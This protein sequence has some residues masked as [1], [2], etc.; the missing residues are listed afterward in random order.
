MLRVY[1]VGRKGKKSEEAADCS[2]TPGNVP[3]ACTIRLQKELADL[4][5][6]SG[7][8]VQPSDT[9]TKFTLQVQMTEGYWKNLR[10]QFAFDIPDDYPHSPPKVICCSKIYHPNIDEHGNIC[11]NI[12]RED[13]RPILSINAV[14]LGIWHILAEPNTTDPLNKGAAELLLKDKYSFERKARNF[15]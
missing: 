8:T 1:G 6:P 7:F 3:I 10:I 5:L 12:L 14:I 2:S 4:D 9:L 13:W 11:L 15:H